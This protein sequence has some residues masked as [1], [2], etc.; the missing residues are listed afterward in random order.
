M[1][2]SGYMEFDEEQYDRFNEIGEFDTLIEK[3]S[4]FRINIIPK[5]TIRDYFAI[6]ACKDHYE[7]FREAF[8]DM[9]KSKWGQ[10]RVCR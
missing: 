2:I 8:A 3:D 10:L 7:M 1:C 6:S 5:G 9:K 4:Y